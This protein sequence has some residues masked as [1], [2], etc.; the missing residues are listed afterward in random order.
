M[1]VTRGRIPQD[2]SGQVRAD[3]LGM[4]ADLDSDQ[5]DVEVL[6]Q[7]LLHATAEVGG[8][9]GMAHLR[10]PEVL[11]GAIELLASTGLSPSFTRPWL[12]VSEDD[13][14]APARAV[15]EN[16][17]VYL[18]TVAVPKQ[19]YANLSALTV[20]DPAVVNPPTE[21]DAVGVPAGAGIAAV[22]LPGPGGPLGALSVVFPA[23]QVPEPGQRAFLAE[24]ARWAGGRLRLSA[25]GPAGVSPTLLAGDVRQP[26]PEQPQTAQ[27]ETKE[28]WDFD[29]RTGVIHSRGGTLY[30][31]LGLPRPC[32]VE[33][34]VDRVHPEDLPWVTAE[35][36]RALRTSG[37]YAVE[38]RMRAMDGTY[39]W[40][41]SRADV[42][43]DEHGEQAR[44]VGT[45]WNTTGSHA[46]L[47]SVGRA[48]LHMSDGFLSVTEDWRVG[49]VNAAAERLLGSV[50]RE[51]V[52][53]PLWEAPA[54]RS[55][56]GVETRCRQAV[57]DGRPVSFEMPGPGSDQ[58]YQVRLVPIPE[59]L[60]AY[61]ADITEPR[62]REA[63]HQA[64]ERAAAE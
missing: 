15:R 31:S 11:A 14:A 27:P 51:M 16:G 19:A 40:I 58:W 5:P 35:A 20:T 18:P 43:T 39:I 1:S 46:G 56:P 32:P 12:H 2:R 37:V 36:D 55:V 57:A 61:V 4:L 62:R 22:P 64:A 28:D 3:R 53:R 41:R 23:S 30:E 42:V 49:F 54:L 63:E 34:W 52:G 8:L 48:L 59:G 60:T 25:P 50:S 6:R 26:S 45:S 13:S 21:R 47:E 9:G 29:R 38:H 24:V 17:F 33:T 10:A 44:V 7:A